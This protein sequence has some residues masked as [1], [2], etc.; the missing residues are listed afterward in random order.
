[1]RLPRDPSG[2]PDHVAGMIVQ[3]REQHR[4]PALDDR[5]VQ[6]VAD[7]Q[8]VAPVGLEPAEG[9]RR[10]PVGPGSQLQ[11]G[12][13]ALQGPGRGCPPSLGLDDPCDVRGGAGRAFPF[14]PGRQVQHVGLG[15]GLRLPLGRDQR[16]EPPGPPGPDPT[17][18]AGP[19]HRGRLPERP[20]A[21]PLGQLADQ[22]AP[23][24]RR[25]GETAGSASGRIRA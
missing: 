25:A 13:V 8:L 14:Q 6:P 1:M 12:E 5:A 10:R 4:P 20:G 3:Q 9:P 21:R 24:G 16:V 22:P 23:L 11:A 15:A 18:Q 17:V 19:G 2:A 7:P